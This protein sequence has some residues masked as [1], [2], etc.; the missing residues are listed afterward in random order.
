MLF[1]QMNIEIMNDKQWQR[2]PEKSRHKK[3]KSL[4]F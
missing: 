1:I 4:F 2:V 3:Q